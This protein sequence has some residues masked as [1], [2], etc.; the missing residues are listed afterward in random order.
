MD[1]LAFL[2]KAMEILVWPVAVILGLYILRGPIGEFIVSIADAKL[3]V[4]SGDTTIEARLGTVQEKLEKTVRPKPL[5]PPLKKLVSSSPAEAIDLSWRNLE[6]TATASAGAGTHIAPI[7]VAGLLLDKKILNENEAGAFYTLYE[8]RNAVTKPDGKV[9]TDV[10]S[11]STYSTLAN[12]L[13]ETIKERG[14]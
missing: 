5:P 9:V 11:A 10:S 4:K 3:K 2:L 1:A 6:A 14:T 12:A 13:T 7:T 8:V